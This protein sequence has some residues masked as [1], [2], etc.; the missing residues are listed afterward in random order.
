MNTSFEV[1]Y[2]DVRICTL[3]VETLY[4]FPQI[5]QLCYFR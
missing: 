5:Q 2:V 3:Y 1:K 4:N